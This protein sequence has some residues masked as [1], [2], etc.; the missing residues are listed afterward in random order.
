MKMETASQTGQK[1]GKAIVMG[2]SIAGLWTARMLAD[3]FD[4]VIVLERDQLPEGAEFRSG[5]P[6]ARQYHGLLQ[7]G[8]RQ[9]QLWFPGLDEELIAA[10]AV[11]RRERLDMRLHL[12]A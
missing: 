7:S 9:M 8:L 6:Q 1:F 2:A 10:G 3:H 12:D 4:E 11:L 5:T